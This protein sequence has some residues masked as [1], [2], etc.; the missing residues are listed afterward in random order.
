MDGPGLLHGPF[1]QGAFAFPEVGK[2]DGRDVD[3]VM[4]NPA[5]A[6]AIQAGDLFRSAIRTAASSGTVVT[7]AGWDL[8]V[9]RMV[10]EVVTSARVRSCHG[11]G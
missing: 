11:P 8:T 3:E 7:F 4:T 2:A 9:E 1:L 5:E 6:G 10:I